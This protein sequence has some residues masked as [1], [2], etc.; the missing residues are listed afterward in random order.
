M[1]EE[2][3]GEEEALGARVEGEAGVE[4]EA[5]GTAFGGEAGGTAFGGEIEGKSCRSES[6]IG[7]RREQEQG[8]M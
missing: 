6:Q 5:R 8:D 4:A 2:E 3:Q 1:F 7:E